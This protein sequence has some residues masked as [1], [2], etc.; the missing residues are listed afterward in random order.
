MARRDAERCGYTHDVSDRELFPDIDG[1]TWRCPHPADGEDRCIFH[2]PLA[3]KD[4]DEVS[5]ALLAVVQDGY[6]HLDLGVQ[7]RLR[8]VG[9]EFGPLSLASASVATSTRPATRV[10]TTSDSPYHRAPMFELHLDLRSTRVAGS[11]DLR[12]SEVRL[13]VMLGDSVVEGLV[14]LQRATVNG[15]VTARTCEFR[16]GLRFDY[17]E[18]AGVLEVRE[19]VFSEGP[20]VAPVAS[21]PGSSAVNGEASSFERLTLR[22]CDVEG[23]VWVSGAEG[24]KVGFSRSEVDGNLHLGMV[25][26]ESDVMVTQATVSGRLEMD[27][28]AVGEGAVSDG[29]YLTDTTVEADLTLQYATLTRKLFADGLDLGG[30]LDAEGVTVDGWLSAEGATVEGDLDCEALTVTIV[31]ALPDATV[32]GAAS[33]A[34]ATVE[35]G[36]D[37]EGADVE[38]ELRFSEASVDGNLSVESSTVGGDVDARALAVEGT[39]QCSGVEVAGAADFGSVDVEGDLLLAN[40]LVSGRCDLSDSVLRSRVSLEGT[41]IEVDEEVAVDLRGSTVGALACR[42]RLREGTAGIVACSDATLEA[43]SLEQPADAVV[44][45]ELTGAAIGDVRFETSDG[46]HDFGYARIVAPEFDGYGFAAKKSALNADDWVVH[47]VHEECVPPLATMDAR[48]EATSDAE[49]LRTLLESVPQLRD[50]V[51]DDAFPSGDGGGLAEATVE[52]ALD[53]GAGSGWSPGDDGPVSVRPGDL[54]GA[55][56]SHTLEVADAVE[57]VLTRGRPGGPLGAALRTGA[58]TDRLAE[59]ARRLEERSVEQSGLPSLQE[60]GGDGGSGDEPGEQAELGG[61]LADALAK[62]YRAPSE[63]PPSP[64]QAEV[65]YQAAK[66]G[67]LD[68][69]ENEAAAEFFRH[70]MAFRRRRHLDDLLHDESLLDRFRASKRLVSNRLI[71]LTT[72]YG[73][74]TGRPILAS[75]VVVVAFAAGYRAL[76]QPPFGPGASWGT[77]LLFSFQS[78]ISFILGPVPRTDSLGVQVMTAVEG[79]VGAFFVALFVFTLTRSVTR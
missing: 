72:G 28:V 51:L 35:N 5:E 18:V 48:E 52:V 38:G 3:E 63:V 16:G 50:H 68:E 60:Q 73:E 15:H 56:E 78:F 66:N 67:A 10:E 62:A 9:A 11:L 54:T 22:G 4:A 70:E 40:A 31:A 76:P 30:D 23:D 69:G 33:F 59:L 79:F 14:T 57:D 34:H 45:Y 71:D 55:V 39:L 12:G 13:G 2:R 24:E 29:V 77:Y 42:P 21:G 37:F 46:D 43:G 53:S 25:D 64:V 26:V 58:V 27:G 75:L 74:R 19:G 65:T 7:E 6:D 1:E 32:G 61:E 36:F 17:A 49:S 20:G 44:V 41:R 47:D 8:F